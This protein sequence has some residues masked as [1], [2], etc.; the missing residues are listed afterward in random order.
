MEMLITF[1]FRFPNFLL[2]N[3]DWLAVLLGAALLHWYRQSTTPLPALG[4]S[5]AARR[6]SVGG[7][8]F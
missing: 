7:G 6:A 5:P 8:R 3:R 1:L 4:R 2:D